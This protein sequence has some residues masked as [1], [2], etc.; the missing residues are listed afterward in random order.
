[1]KTQIVNKVVV[2]CCCWE[3]LLKRMAAEV[4]VQTV[5][6]GRTMVGGRLH[7]GPLADSS[8]SLISQS[9]LIAPEPNK[10]V[11]APKPRL[12]PKPF[13][14]DKNLTVKPIVAPKPLQRSRLE[15]ARLPGYKPQPSC[16]P[17]PPQPAVKAA[18]T[19]PDRPASTSFKSTNKMNAGQT[20][21]PVAQPFKPAPPLASGDHNE[22]EKK[23]KASSLAHSHSLKKPSAAEWSGNAI[24]KAEKD[25]SITRA[26]SMG[27]LTE[28]GK[29]EEDEDRPEAA[30]PLRPQPRTSRPRPVSELFL[31]SPSKAS[32]PV[33][34]SNWA[35]RR[36]LS[37]DLT[38]KFESIGLSL[39]R[40]FPKMKENTPEEKGPPQER[41]PEATRSEVG[42]TSTASDQSSKKE[43]GVGRR[44]DSVRSRISHLLDS[45]ST[46]LEPD[47]PSTA[48]AGLDAEPAVG[49]KQLIRQLTEDASPAQSPVSRPPLKPRPLPLDLTKR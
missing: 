31:H 36:P 1:M 46:F 49:V 12:T 2:F 43:A 28:V 39:H 6:V 42:P 5:E 4:E 47:P 17:K 25:R 18:P 7:L 45:P 16:T 38:A 9:H 30:V 33:Q 34:V 40:K 24:D 8:N 19:D 26:K 21:K 20:T 10:P 35:G 37:A 41:E 14:V 32:D 15:S 11:P 13:A 44:S 22:R 29:E 23:L 48:Q 3:G 27:F